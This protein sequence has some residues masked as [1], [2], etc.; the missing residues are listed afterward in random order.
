[1]RNPAGTTKMTKIKA[2]YKKEMLDLLRDK[3][4]L[5]MMV[6]VPLL[7]YPLIMMGSMLFGSAI[8]SSM[9]SDEYHIAVV[10]D[11]ADS[12]INGYDGAA[13]RKLLADTEDELE[14]H[15]IIE[16][17][18][19]GE[20]AGALGAETIDAYIEVAAPDAADDGRN[21]LT[22][23]YLSSKSASETAA[24]MIADKLELY[25]KQ[26]S[27]QILTALGVEN[28]DVLLEPVA[29]AFDDQSA[30]E[31]RVGRLLGMMLPMLMVTSILMGAFYAAVDATAGEKERGTLE[32][33]LT[34]P[35]GNDELITGKFFAVSTVAVASAVLNLV[36]ML[37][38]SIYFYAVIQTED[39]QK[40]HINL[41][42]F[43]PALLI[44][45]LCTVAFALFIS[46]VTMCVTTFA[47]SF[48]EANNYATPLMLVVMF[49][50]FVTFVP[51]I[52]FTGLLAAVPVVNISLLISSILVFEYDFSVIMI[53]LATNIVYAAIAILLLI[54]LYDS[55]EMMF[56]EG[57]TS[58]Q[59][60]TSRK[61]IKG[62][63]V[64]TMSD[65]VLVVAT[66]LLLLLYVGSV[67]QAKFM[68]WGLFITQLLIIGVP[69][70]AVWYTKRDVR[71]T[72]S[73][74]LPKPVW[75]LGA[76]L[77]ET[78]CYMLVLVV[79]LVLGRLFPQ[80]IQT[81][82]ETM[83][84]I[85]GGAGFVPALLVIA[86]A[87]AVCEEALFRGYFFSAAEKR[88]R[89]AAAILIGGA[90]FGIYHLSFVKFFT[91]GILGI[92]FCYVVYRTKSILLTSLMHFLNN[93]VS[94]VAIF[95]PERMQR[96]LPVLFQ[97]SLDVGEALV[98]VIAG[99][100]CMAGGLFLCTRTSKE[101]MSA[102]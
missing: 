75:V 95:Y 101:R 45:L 85:L 49:A 84:H 97:E 34:L 63:G 52:E 81:V 76:V 72:F 100:V 5:I 35:V 32:T 4:T 44:V 17:I 67:V 80:D 59:I 8:A 82:N 46:A 88:L 74:R 69:L 91:T 22:I 79:S 62:G 38:M 23:Y 43:I 71:E 90:V 47:R 70:L 18:P 94:V 15:L 37:L 53:V 30:N 11:A 78:G 73:L 93:A 20:C 98:L 33:L 66:A 89:P 12:G 92:L 68:L 1:M 19:S 27:R 96:L 6:V 25:K 87:P 14:Y 36:F 42:D 7:L 57:D 24:D 56:G 65:A 61:E 83:D 40:L 102:G 64:P 2:I 29:V 60:F 99:T 26:T 48:K 21:V 10:D 54:R 28:P 50:S 9:Q 41:T 3:K 51:N 13:L 55:E 86:L 58:I 39:A 16:D 31:E 77:A